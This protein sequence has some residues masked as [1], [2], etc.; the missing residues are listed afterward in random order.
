MTFL[1]VFNLH[2]NSNAKQKQ[3]KKLQLVKLDGMAIVD[4][5]A[6]GRKFVDCRLQIADC[7][8]QIVD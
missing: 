7:R 3:C 2:S 6:M 8:L 4:W 1:P 5:T